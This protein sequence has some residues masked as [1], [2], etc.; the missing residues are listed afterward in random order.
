[1]QCKPT[2]YPGEGIY[3]QVCHVPL[4]LFIEVNMSARLTK[5][6]EITQYLTW[7]LAS[8]RIG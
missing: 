2:V 3:V 8:V 5:S 7:L 6:P 4:C 1:M